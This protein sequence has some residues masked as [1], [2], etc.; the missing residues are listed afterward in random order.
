MLRAKVGATEDGRKK[1]GKQTP[2]KAELSKRLGKTGHVSNLSKTGD[3]SKTGVLSVGGSA[4]VR[5]DIE[6]SVAG[7]LGGGGLHG[8]GLRIVQGVGL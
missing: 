5:Q 1:R 6:W 4:K 3:K 8:N 7:R 2:N